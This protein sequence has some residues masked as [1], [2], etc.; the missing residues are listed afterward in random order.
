V[1]AYEKDIGNV[2]DVTDDV[3]AHGSFTWTPCLDAAG[4]YFYCVGAVSIPLQ[5]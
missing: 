5:V 1:A 3:A 4:F 2:N